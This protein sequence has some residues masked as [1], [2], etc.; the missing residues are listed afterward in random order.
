M[1]ENAVFIFGYIVIGSIVGVFILLLVGMFMVD[2]GSGEKVDRNFERYIDRE[3]GV[4]CW[5]VSITDSGG[6]S[7]LPIDKTNLGLE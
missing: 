3:A 7:C 4:V 6:I 2:R 5:K 1:K